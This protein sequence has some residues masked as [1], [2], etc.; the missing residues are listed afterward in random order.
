MTYQ[1]LPLRDD[2]PCDPEHEL[3]VSISVLDEMKNM[4]QIL[5]KP[6]QFVRIDFYCIHSQ[7]LIGELTFFH[8]GGITW[9]D[10]EEYDLEFG[11]KW[12]LIY[13]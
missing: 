1:L 5:A 6:F 11:S 9:F 2:V 3:S 12:K 8:N 13:E 4:A 10:P 7:I